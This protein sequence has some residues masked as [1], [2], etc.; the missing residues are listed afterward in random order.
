[1]WSIKWFSKFFREVPPMCKGLPSSSY[2]GAC[3]KIQQVWGKKWKL[4]PH[5]N[6]GFSWEIY[7]CKKS[8]HRFGTCSNIEERDAEDIMRAAKR[9]KQLTEKAVPT[10]SLWVEINMEDRIWPKELTNRRCSYQEQFDWSVSFRYV[11]DK[12]RNLILCK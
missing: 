12:A 7:T 10:I 11:T 8:R 2:N 3:L 5:Q 4:T 9:S 6:R 1:M